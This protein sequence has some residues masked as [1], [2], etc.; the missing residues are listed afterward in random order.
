MDLNEMRR[1]YKEQ[2]A[3]TLKNR[4]SVVNNYI[5]ADVPQ[6]KSE[7]R[8]ENTFSSQQVHYNSLTSTNLSDNGTS[9]T[10]VLEDIRNYS[11]NGI[12]T[13][14]DGA[15]YNGSWEKG[16]RNGKGTQTWADCSKYTGD[17]KNDK[18]SGFGLMTWSDGNYFKGRWKD[19]YFTEGDFYFK[20]GGH[21]RGSFN[22]DGMRN[23]YGTYFW[24]DG[25]FHMGIWKNDMR[26]GHGQYVNSNGEI[27]QEGEWYNDE[28]NNNPSI[29]QSWQEATQK[30][31]N[32]MF[33][34]EK[35]PNAEQQES[36]KIIESIIVPIRYNEVWSQIVRIWQVF[37]REHKLDTKS[38]PNPYGVKYNQRPF[39]IT[40]SVGVQELIKEIINFL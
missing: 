38:L 16:H 21:Y 17:W 15:T 14:P 25:S 7:D 31:I 22:E 6:K 11:G 12:Y 40:G 5:V 39:P 10:K 8:E 19:D 26:H 34:L 24:P 32:L 29:S 13:F 9:N 37:V 2:K 20:S 36:L 3:Q 23:G 35:C 4:D 28:Y 1:R 27:V 33:Q 30:A 18:R